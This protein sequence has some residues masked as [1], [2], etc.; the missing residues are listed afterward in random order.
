[1]P[2]IQLLS[3]R[4]N[5]KGRRM[6]T[7]CLETP[8]ANTQALSNNCRDPNAT[9]TRHCARHSVYKYKFWGGLDWIMIRNQYQQPLATTGCIVRTVQ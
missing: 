2:I 6:V 3:V 1:M 7:L 4:I 8:A 9:R 5:K